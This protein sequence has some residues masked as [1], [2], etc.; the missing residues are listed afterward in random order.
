MDP[1]TALNLTCALMVLA[2]AVAMYLLGRFWFGTWGGWLAAAAYLYAPYFH[3]DLFV[4]HALAEFAAFPFYP[5]AF[6]GFARY[7]RDRD[8]RFLLLGAAA[9]AAV[10]AAHHPAAFLF[11]PLLLAFV[12][13]KR[14]SNSPGGCWRPNSARWLWRWAWGPASGRRRFSSAAS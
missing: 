9:Y 3:V 13:F 6:Y 2:A 5:L 7:A 11:S 1:L 4:R 10:I 8:S 14:C 12:V